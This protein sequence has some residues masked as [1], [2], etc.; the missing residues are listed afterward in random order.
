MQLPIMT[1]VLVLSP[2]ILLVPIN[3]HGIIFL[4]FALD[5]LVCIKLRVNYFKPAN[6]LD[7]IS[8]II[9]YV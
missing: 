4:C 6:A 5:N 3:M 7:N 8:P 1:L 9:K 2:A